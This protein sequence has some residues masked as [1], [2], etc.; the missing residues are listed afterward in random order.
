MNQPN[1]TLPADIQTTNDIP[2][3]TTTPS[4]IEDRDRGKGVEAMAGLRKGSRS[5]RAWDDMSETDRRV[6]LESVRARRQA[7]V[8]RDT[9]ELMLW[10][11]RAGR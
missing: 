5:T 10:L 6:L 11:S 9:R 3:V 7:R 2:T 4:S 1:Q 8:E